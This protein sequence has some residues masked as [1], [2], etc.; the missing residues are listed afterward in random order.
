MPAE[1]A[2][3]IPPSN[4]DT[5]LNYHNVI[6]CPPEGIWT[7]W[8]CLER[9]GIE[10]DVI[11]CR[12]VTDPKNHLLDSLSDDTRLVG[13]TTFFDSFA[14]IERTSSV[15][16]REY[17]DTTLIAG[18]PLATNA[19]SH[20]LL[21]TDLD[22]VVCGEGEKAW[23]ALAMNLTLLLG[24]PAIQGVVWSDAQQKVQ[25]GEIY[26][27]LDDLPDLNWDFLT[28]D[29]KR[30]QNTFMYSISRGC[31]NRCRYCTSVFKTM[32]RKSPHK[33]NKD[34]SRLRDDYSMDNII[35]NDSDFLYEQACLDYLI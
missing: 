33:V 23:E 6:N 24:R 9:L 19:Y 34:F 12:S 13:Y 18:G 8:T 5:E 7:L 32:R 4:Y 25:R 28:D 15:I 26:S 31:K 11:D 3:V 10:C 17:I 1:I 21:S 22:A 14:F 30:K 29:Q 35:I 2:L 16:K 27:N 20:F